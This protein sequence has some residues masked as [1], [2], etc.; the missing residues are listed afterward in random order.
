MVK[1]EMSTEQA[2]E[3]AKNIYADIENY[4]QQHLSEF[5]E[6]LKSENYAD[7]TATEN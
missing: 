5:E 6:F 7:S 1:I 2:R 4:V 3:I